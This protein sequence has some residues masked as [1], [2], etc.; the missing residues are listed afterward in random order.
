MNAINATI[1]EGK[2]LFVEKQIIEEKSENSVEDEDMHID[3][4]V[5]EEVQRTNSIVFCTN[6][7][8]KSVA[9][10]KFCQQCGTQLGMV[11]N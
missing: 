11:R 9:G 7:G 2:A 6:C 10:A 8:A 1:A 5:L 4:K 3:A